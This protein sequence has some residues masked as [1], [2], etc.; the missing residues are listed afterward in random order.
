MD[1]YVQTNDF[2]EEVPQFASKLG[3]VCQNEAFGNTKIEMH[4]RFTQESL[5]DQFSQ[6]VRL[7][8]EVMH[9][10]RTP[11]LITQAI[12]NSRL[13]ACGFKTVLDCSSECDRN[14]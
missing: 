2:S 8:P 11:D 13:C 3:G 6:G 9:V 12:A 1:I 4:F 14:D 10:A 5:A 7:F